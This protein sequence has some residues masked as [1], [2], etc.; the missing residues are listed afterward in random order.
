MQGWRCKGG[1][2]CVLTRVS[3]WVFKATPFSRAPHPHLEERR[4]AVQLGGRA[5]RFVPRL[6][7]L[8]LG[9][10]GVG[11]PGCEGPRGVFRGVP[12]LTSARLRSLSAAA[13]ASCTLPLTYCRPTR[14]QGSGKRV[15]RGRKKGEGRG[16]GGGG[17]ARLGTTGWSY[18]TRHGLCR[19]GPHPQ[20]GY[21]QLFG[22]Q[23]LERHVHVAL[24]LRQLLS[25]ARRSG[26]PG[27]SK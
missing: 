8:R 21:F 27:W 4:R 26:L 14:L 18:V 2:R 6:G 24:G 20:V 17:L 16:R 9:G 7:Q 23:A 5:L 12:S 11:V 19:G 22:H 25:E 15:G 3:R 13:A 10:G 1:V